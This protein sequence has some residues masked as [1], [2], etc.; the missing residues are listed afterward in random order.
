MGRS[1]YDRL[2]ETYRAALLDV[3]NEINQLLVIGDHVVVRWTGYG[4]H[5]SADLIGI[6]ASRKS[7]VAHVNYLLRGEGDRIAELWNPWN[8]LTVMQQLQS[9]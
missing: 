8:N 4:T 7:V 2:I 5:T 1:M 3:R 6:S 9:S